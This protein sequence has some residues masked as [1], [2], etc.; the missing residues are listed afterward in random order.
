M[1]VLLPPFPG[2]FACWLPRCNKKGP[3]ALCLA[4]HSLGGPAPRQHYALLAHGRPPF[5]LAPHC[6]PPCTS[7]RRCLRCPLQAC[8]QRLG[9]ILQTGACRHGQA[10]GCGLEEHRGERPLPMAPM[11][12]TLLPLAHPAPPLLPMAPVACSDVAVCQV[13][14]ISL[15]RLS[16]SPLAPVLLPH[17]EGPPPPL[18]E[19]R[20]YS[21]NLLLSSSAH[22]AG[23]PLCPSARCEGQSE[24]RGERGGHPGARGG[25]GDQHAAGT[26][27]HVQVREARGWRG[28]GRRAIR[29]SRHWRRLW[30][31][32]CRCH[33]GSCTGEGGTIGMQVGI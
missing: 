8:V 3:R 4:S 27:S 9:H 5:A 23:V 11:V 24:A 31:S 20:S 25:A 6:C 7:R 10:R 19:P 13:S 30:G 15:L 26:A 17:F 18:C 32:A 33:C 1:G 14:V 21:P 2:P 28:G 29:T 16:S 12:C 22:C